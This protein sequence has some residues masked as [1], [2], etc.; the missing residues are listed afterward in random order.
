MGLFTGD[1]TEANGVLADQTTSGGSNWI[2]NLGSLM[3]LGLG[4]YTAVNTANQTTANRTPGP[5]PAPGVASATP[6]WQTWALIAAGV[7]TVVLVFSMA[8]RK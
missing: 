8:F 6:K 2:A 7:L 4:A 5:A 1:T 3:G